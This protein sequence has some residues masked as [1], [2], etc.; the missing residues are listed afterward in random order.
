[1][2]VIVI[3]FNILHH[4]LNY[5][6]MI[7]DDQIIIINNN[8][9]SWAR[10]AYKA[11]RFILWWITLTAP[12]AFL[13]TLCSRSLART[14]THTHIFLRNCSHK[15]LIW[16]LHDGFGVCVRLHE[17]LQISLLPH[18]IVIFNEMRRQRKVTN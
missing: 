14:H 16:I 17:R 18:L 11:F 10:R 6:I 5:A 1:M 7:I 9:I 13:N 2:F 15:C 12:L 3:I 4:S 8:N